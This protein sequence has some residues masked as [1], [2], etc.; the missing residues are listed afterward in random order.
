MPRLRSY[1]ELLLRHLG[2]TVIL[3]LIAVNHRSLSKILLNQYPLRHRMHPRGKVP[4]GFVLRLTY[5]D[6]CLMPVC[7]FDMSPPIEA[8][9]WVLM[10][11]RLRRVNRYRRLVLVVGQ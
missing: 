8:D 4:D 3:G 6:P 7:L 5:F 9:F 10:M 1:D 2:L 11:M